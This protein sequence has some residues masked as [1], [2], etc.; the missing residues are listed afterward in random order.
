MQTSFTHK[1]A[2]TSGRLRWAA[3]GRMASTGGEGVGRSRRPNANGRRV[4]GR[5]TRGSGAAASSG[6][7]GRTQGVFGTIPP[8]PAVATTG[9]A[10]MFS[11]RSP[12][13]PSASH[14]IPPSSHAVRSEPVGVLFG[15]TG[16]GRTLGHGRC[17]SSNE[18]HTSLPGH[19]YNCPGQRFARFPAAVIDFR[20]PS[21]R[22]SASSRSRSSAPK[23]TW[24][25]ASANRRCPAWSAISR[26]I[27]WATQR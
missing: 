5:V 3:G 15:A 12:G 17:W 2:T 11:T 8:L 9:V 26:C 6:T 14:S 16:T 27:S 1:P 20:F 18:P 10:G 25:M 13:S 4:T 24:D 19:L 7:G 22:R 21:A 23:S